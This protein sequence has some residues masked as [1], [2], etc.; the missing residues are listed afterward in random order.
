ML[1]KGED[2][3]IDI[4][5]SFSSRDQMWNLGPG[6]HH[7][8]LLET[9]NL[10]PVARLKKETWSAELGANFR[11]DEL[12]LQQYAEMTRQKQTGR[13]ELERETAGIFSAVEYE[14]WTGWHFSAAAR[15]EKTSI[16][17]TA[18]SLLFPDDPSL[19]FS[20]ENDEINRAYQIGV[21]WEPRA[22]LDFW[23]RY[24]R[25]YRLPSTDEIASYQ[26]FPLSE[27]FNAELKAETGNNYE[28]G[29][30]YRIDGWKLRGNGFLQQLTGEIGYDFQK[31]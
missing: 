14:P 17:A 8:N 16:A 9:W 30:E 13:A 11:R 3:N 7:D 19:N 2:L 26:G 4:P 31:T 18:Q 20:S 12:D 5:I 25:L 6:S 1:G 21:R 24:D 28:L 22:D 23:L 27:P 29:G 10:S 15:C